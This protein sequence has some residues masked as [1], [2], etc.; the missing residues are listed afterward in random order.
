[1]ILIESEG[2]LYRGTDLFAPEEV[3]DYPRKRWVP[4]HD[5]RWHAP[6]TVINE[7]RAE[8]LKHD[9]PAAEHFMYYDS[10][11]WR[12]PL[13][14]AYLEAVRSPKVREAI[15]RRQ[16]ELAEQRHQASTAA[17]PPSPDVIPI[18]DGYGAPLG[19]RYPMPAKPGSHTAYARGSDLVVEWYDF[20]E[21]APYES[22]NLLIF[23]RATQLKLA[24][25]IRAD[26]ALSPHGLAS[27][28]AAR[29]DSYFDVKAFAAERGLPYGIE[30]D[31]E[32]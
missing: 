32:P 21:D 26:P 7:A 4:Y 22:A 28:I 10:P 20:G 8:T 29:F 19:H 25:L 30:V 5:G 3:W 11:P 2:L 17:A 24:E 18:D 27:K 23:D 16:A 15:A 6:G 1:M 31:F 12:Q 14:E 13:G 9:N